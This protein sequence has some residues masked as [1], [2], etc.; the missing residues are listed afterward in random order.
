[1]AETFFDFDRS[2]ELISKLHEVRG[3]GLGE[4]CGWRSWEIVDRTTISATPQR[5]VRPD[6]FMISRAS[7]PNWN[8]LDI[9]VASQDGRSE[10]QLAAGG[11]IPGAMFAPEM[12]D[13]TLDIGAVAAL[14]RIEVEVE[15][16]GKNPD[17]EVFHAVFMCNAVDGGKVPLPLISSGPIRSSARVAELGAGKRIGIQ[18]DDRAWVFRQDR[19]TSPFTVHVE[20]SDLCCE[21]PSMEDMV[22]VDH[23]DGNGSVMRSGDPR[24]VGPRGVARPE[25]VPFKPDRDHRAGGVDRYEVPDLWAVRPRVLS[26]H[27][28][29][30]P[31][32]RLFGIDESTNQVVFEIS[33]GTATDGT[34]FGRF[35]KAGYT[36][37][38]W[39]ETRLLEADLRDPA[40]PESTLR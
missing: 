16:I 31:H 13:N 37:S 22:Y 21:Q 3:T 1:M 2:A 33:P 27:V 34:L 5:A 40:F 30:A 39:E 20:P 25:R 26:L 8:I 17:G 6:R 10:S 36:P 15:Y 29:E 14:M 24:P 4:L 19:R 23:D 38:W 18:I 32:R 9:R 7:A 35:D 11:G 28:I 12:V